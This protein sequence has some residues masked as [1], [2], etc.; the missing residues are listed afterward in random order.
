M[1]RFQNLGIWGEDQALAH[2]ISKGLVLLE[3]NLRVV[4]GEVD[5]IMDDEGTLFF[6][7]VKTRRSLEYSTPEEGITHTKKEK[8]YRAAIE[9]IER[10]QFNPCDWRMDVVAIECSIEDEVTRIDHYVNI[11]YQPS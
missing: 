7:E 8:I 5:L 9:H 4:V 11:E 1:K 3:R 6:V 10:N 2:L